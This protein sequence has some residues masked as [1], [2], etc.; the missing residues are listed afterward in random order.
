VSKKKPKI[1]LE[2]FGRYSKWDKGSRQLPKILEFTH[3]IEA[4]EGNEFGLVL[5]IEGG[6]G[7][8]LNYIIKHPPFK[9]E[10]NEVEPNFV[11]EYYITSNHHNFF[12]GDCI[13]LPVED[14]VGTWEI[15]VYHEG[16]IIASQVFQIVLP[17]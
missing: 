16:K 10:S 5:K 17:T 1:K 2:S 15:T 11:G 8:K 14:K 13:W 6:K 9:N 12:I 4:I 7:I 3:T